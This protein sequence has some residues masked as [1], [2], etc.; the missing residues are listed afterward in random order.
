MNTDMTGF[1][2]LCLCA[3][4]ERSLSIGRLKNNYLKECGWLSTVKHD[5]CFDHKN[6]TKM[7]R[8][9]YTTLTTNIRV[10]SRSGG[11]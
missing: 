4:D 11:Q 3:L 9:F 8:M 1:R 2:S 7:A 5:F 6:I 10:K